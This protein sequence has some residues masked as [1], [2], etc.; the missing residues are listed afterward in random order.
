[1]HCLFLEGFAELHSVDHQYGM[2]NCFDLHSKKKKQ[3]FATS[4]L[5]IYFISPVIKRQLAGLLRSSPAV[6]RRDSS[7]KVVHHLN[8]NFPP[9]NCQATTQPVN[10]Q[11]RTVPPIRW[12]TKKARSCHG[13]NFSSNQRQP[14]ENMSHLLCGAGLHNSSRPQHRSLKTM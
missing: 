12:S 14:Y 8:A 7:F 11:S 3:L 6:S 4:V 1:M 2:N 9:L 10:L 5:F 13:L